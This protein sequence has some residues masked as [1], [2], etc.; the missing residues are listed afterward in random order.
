MLNKFSTILLIFSFA[1]SI[2]AQNENDALRFSFLTY[3]G[4]ARY[5]GMSGAFSALGADFSVLSTN[6][7]GIGSFKK[8]RVMF[9][10]GAVM[11]N[12]SADYWGENTKDDFVRSNINNL[13]LILNLKPYTPNETGWKTV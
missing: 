12:T 13:G 5:M 2:F 3:G 11:M 1:T 8:S 9:S 7:A 4:T 6:P 10:A